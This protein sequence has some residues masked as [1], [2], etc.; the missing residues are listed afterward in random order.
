MQTGF[1]CVIHGS[2]GKHFS[3][4][5][6]VHKLFTEAGIT[7]LAPKA[8]EL[9]TSTDGFALF[10]DEVG[11]DPRLVELLYLHQI[12]QLGNDGFSYFVNPDGYIG[13]SASYEL[14]I[15]QLTNTRCFFSDSLDDHPAYIHQN[16]VWSAENLV[17]YIVTNNKLPSPKVRQNEKTIH[18]LWQDLIVP[19][20]VVAAGAIIERE[21]LD[22]TE[23]LLVKTHKWGNR[24]SIVGGKVRRNETLRDALLREVHEET[25]LSGKIGRHLATFDQIKNSGY[26]KRGINHIF[27][28]NIVRVNSDRVKLNDEAQSYIWATADEALKH[29]DIEPNAKTTLKLYAKAT[30]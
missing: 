19:G 15:A 21:A 7:V 16:S 14:A 26:Y 18:K 22:Q 25:G 8:S 10:E 5:Q 28:D 4:I 24:Y 27:V 30:L 11:Q 1:S 17:D 12:K 20:S 13:K 6:R 29:L 3:E 9:T 2:F 23:V